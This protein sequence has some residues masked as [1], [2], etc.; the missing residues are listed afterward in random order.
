MMVDLNGTSFFVKASIIGTGVR[1]T[2][3][4]LW[5]S[6]GTTVGTQLL[7]TIVDVEELPQNST[8]QTV[9]LVVAGGKVFCVTL[10]EINNTPGILKLWVSDGTVE[11]TYVVEQLT[12]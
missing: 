11:G 3:H 8:M 6:D 12:P 9:D 10:I 5:R 7:K 2:A 4:E 1:N